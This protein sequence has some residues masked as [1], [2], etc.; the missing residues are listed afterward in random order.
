MKTIILEA[1]QLA[2]LTL[3]LKRIHTILGLDTQVLPHAVPASDA[4]LESDTCADSPVSDL[5]IP[6]LDQNGR[7]SYR[8]VYEY[9]RSRKRCDPDFRKICN[10]E[11]TA[12]VCRR[13]TEIFGWDVE[14]NSLRQYLGRK[15][16]YLTLATIK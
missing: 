12:S 3:C 5:P 15:Q 1:G 2:E 10:E 7:P 16:K 14:D 4:G 8:E 6:R 13:L 9:I 11:S